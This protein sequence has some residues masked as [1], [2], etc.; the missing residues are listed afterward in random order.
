VSQTGEVT[1]RLAASVLY[2][3]LLGGTWA[4][5]HLRVHMLRQVGKGAQARRYAQ[6]NALLFGG[7]MIIMIVET[8]APSG[9]R[10]WIGIGLIG[11]FAGFVL[12][13]VQQVRHGRS[14]PRR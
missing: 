14:S 11:F 3:G 7:L 1:A 12:L 13:L 10:P 9:G 8:W 5:M 4:W 6:R 2:V